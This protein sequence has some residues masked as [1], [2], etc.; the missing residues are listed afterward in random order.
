[1]LFTKKRRTPVSGDIEM[2]EIRSSR[3]LGRKRSSMRTASSRKRSRN[4]RIKIR[5]Y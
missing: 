3:K 4:I 5:R 1:M 2:L